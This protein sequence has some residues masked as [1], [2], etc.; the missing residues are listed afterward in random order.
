MWWRVHPALRGRV[1]C[2]ARV[3][4]CDTGAHLIEDLVLELL[5]VKALPLVYEV[6][7]WEPTSKS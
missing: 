6:V 2:K 4:A 5:P 1:C 3:A 7:K